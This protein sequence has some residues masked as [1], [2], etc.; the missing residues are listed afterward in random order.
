M[1]QKELQYMKYSLLIIS[2][3]SLTIS[4]ARQNGVYKDTAATSFFKRE[5]GVI[6]MDGCYSIPLA[7]N[8]TLWLFGDS[9]MDDYDAA[10]K[11]A[12]CLFEARNSALLQP[13]RNNWAWAGTRALNPGRN[14]YLE[15][16]SQPGHFIWPAC[17]YQLKDTV[18]V[19]GL[20]MKNAKGGLGFAKAGDDVWV[21]IKYPQMQ[22]AG[23]SY[24]PG[25]DSIQFGLGI[26]TDTANGY[27]YI[28]GNKLKGL[29]A[30]VYLARFTTA[31]PATGWQFWNGS[32][33]A[34]SIKQIKPIAEAPSN[35]NNITKINNTY[36]LLS[37]EF[38]I[39]CDNG[40]HI[41][42]SASSSPAGPFTA[43]KVIYT[44]TDTVQ[45]HYPFFY[46]PI[47]HP[48]CINDRNELLVTYSINGYGPCVAN[49]VNNRFNP[50]YYRPQAIRVPVEML[51][52]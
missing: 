15:D 31:R 38:S 16:A 25:L 4:R 9:Y 11:S 23:Y 6:A 14:S 26:I 44:I 32:G 17:G 28:Y 22:V 10:T 24:V 12:P 18:Y 20:N 45:G 21:K 52:K 3:V 1:K 5:K 42:A 13:V 33:W 49:C 7:G 19:F 35:S 37:T 39:Q 40:K 36:V 51:V 29:G 50:E 8:K 41:Y 27:T 2:L 34:N 47:A 43:P 30:M 48:E 46:L